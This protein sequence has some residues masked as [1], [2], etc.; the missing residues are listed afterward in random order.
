MIRKE[1]KARH[2]SRTKATLSLQVRRE[3]FDVAILDHPSKLPP[4]IV[5]S[6]PPFPKCKFRTQPRQSFLRPRRPRATLSR[7]CL[8]VTEAREKDKK[9]IR[10]FAGSL[11]EYQKSS[12]NGYS[13]HKGSAISTMLANSATDKTVRTV[14]Y[15]TPAGA[16]AP[17]EGYCRAPSSP[18][19]S[20]TPTP[21][22]PVSLAAQPTR[23]RDSVPISKMSNGHG[24]YKRRTQWMGCI[25][26]YSTYPSDI[27][28]TAT[29]V[30]S[31]FSSASVVEVSSYY[32]LEFRVHQ[33]S[34]QPRQLSSVICFGFISSPDR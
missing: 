3:P 32:R 7:H 22:A 9:K 2:M 15:R 25:V 18:I 29:S 12:K 28:P 10:K 34:C 6:T 5:Q 13:W 17:R 4:P 20:S 30:P 8:A 27:V 21:T 11:D 33:L 24:R 16:A 31:K 19:G 1:L 23:A 26:T 14:H